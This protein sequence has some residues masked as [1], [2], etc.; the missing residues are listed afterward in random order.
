[1]T[2]ESTNDLFPEEDILAIKE[3]LGFGNEELIEFFRVTGWNGFRCEVC[4][5]PG[6]EGNSSRGVPIPFCL[7]AAPNEDRGDWYFVIRC[8]SC[9]NTKFLDAFFV[10]DHLKGKG[11]L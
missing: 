7:S 6:F 5:G 10:R 11:S 1:M 4:G 9:G 3:I 8:K 2:D